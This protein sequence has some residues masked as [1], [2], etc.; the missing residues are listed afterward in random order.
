MPCGL[1]LFMGVQHSQLYLVYGRCSPRD[2]GTWGIKRLPQ[3]Y[4]WQ[5]QAQY[6]IKH[7]YTC[8]SGAHTCTGTYMPGSGM[9]HNTCT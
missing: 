7:V 8:V 1:W 3:F 4:M 2:A 9:H 6:T 5:T